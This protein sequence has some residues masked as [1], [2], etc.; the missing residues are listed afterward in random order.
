MG[1]EPTVNRNQNPLP[2]VNVGDLIPQRLRA[3]L[4]PA[5]VIVGLVTWLVAEIAVIWL[6]EFADQIFQTSNRILVVV[7]LVT[8]GM[9]TAYK[10]A[11]QL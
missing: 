6:P 5:G 10:P 7:A 2:Q 9:G 3:W 11:P 1:D 4:Y 8:G